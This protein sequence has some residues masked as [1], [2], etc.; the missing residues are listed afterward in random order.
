MA[1]RVDIVPYRNKFNGPAAACR[2]ILL[3]TVMRRY[4]F[5]LAALVALLVALAVRAAAPAECLA[6]SQQCKAECKPC[7]KCEKKNGAGAAKCTKKC[8]KCASCSAGSDTE[9]PA[10]KPSGKPSGKPGDKPGDK[11]SGKPGDKPGDKPGG[12]PGD[13][14]GKGTKGKALPADCK[15]RG[16]DYFDFAAHKAV[17][18]GFSRQ[19]VRSTYHIYTPNYETSSLACADYFWKDPDNGPKLLRYPWLAWCGSL[20]FSQKVCGKCFKITNRATG[21]SIIGRAVDYGGCSDTDGTGIDFDPCGYDSIDTDGAGVR[22]GNMRVD[23]QEVE[24]SAAG[25]FN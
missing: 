18:G 23:I 3:R 8:A 2:G 10:D 9:P 5:V 7:T 21:A 17:P 22:D 12:K 16:A 24:C 15:M 20:P 6:I 4:G 13:K 1:V 11:P 14:P 19:N 25:R